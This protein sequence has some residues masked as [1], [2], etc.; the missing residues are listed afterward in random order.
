MHVVDGELPG[1]KL[2][3]TPG[4]EI[5]G[6]LAQTGN[7]V[8]RFA[9]GDRVGVPWLGLACGRC[10]YCRSG[11]KNL[12]DYARFTGYHTDGGYAQYALA[13]ARYCFP[14]PQVCTG[15]EAAPLFVQA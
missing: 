3:I 2:P 6:R 11:R 4:H 12:C 10:E 5:V 8:D 7:R 13:D 9:H 1:G 14:L 15:A